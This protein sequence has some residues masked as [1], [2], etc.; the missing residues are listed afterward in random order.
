MGKNYRT[1]QGRTIDMSSL[2]AKNEKMRAVGV[3]MKVNARGD[4]IDAHNNIITPVTQKVGQKYQN[5]VGN[6]SA[7][8]KKPVSKPAPKED[9]TLNELSEQAEFDAEDAEIE[10][11]KKKE[12]KK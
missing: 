3:N 7:N 10:Q 2:A 9:L 4:T 1:A 12:L 11:L 5:T 8:V 6:K